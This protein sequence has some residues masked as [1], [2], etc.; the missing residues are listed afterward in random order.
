MSVVTATFLS[1]GAK[2]SAIYQL[3]SID[4]R[5]EVNRIP[6]A[7]LV[8]LDGDSAERKFP[9]S[10][11]KY[12]EP[13]REIEVK[14]RYEAESEDATLFKG[15]V[16]RHAI[17][18]S[19]RGSLLRVDMQDAAIKLTQARQ[20]TVF[21]DKTDSELIGKLVKDGGLKPGTV[22]STQVKHKQMVQYN[23]TSWDFILTRAEANSLLVLSHDGEVSARKAAVNGQATHK[24]KYGIDEIYD[25]ELEA[26]AR[27]QYAEVKGSAWDPKQQKPTEPAQAP[28]R[29]SRVPRPA[30]LSTATRPRA[31]PTCWARSAV[32]SSHVMASNPPPA[33]RRIGP[34]IRSG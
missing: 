30:P 17:E 4:V 13:G 29:S 23:A 1:D 7:S 9:I 32:A 28:S 18:A 22:D 33:A 3:I 5:R 11:A 19:A 31:P 8:L 16:I 21:A 27:D 24:F 10:D 15:P 12:F 26:D 20:S 6:H 14:L 34:R 2:V 25:L